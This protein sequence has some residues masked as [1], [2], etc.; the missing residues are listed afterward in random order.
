MTQRPITVIVVHE[1]SLC[2]AGIR[3]LLVAPDVRIVG[4][5]R[6]HDGALELAVKRRPRL[7]FV[8]ASL[9][10]AH[11]L[12]LVRRLKSAR[13]QTSV[14]VVTPF[15]SSEDLQ[16]A[17]A[18][19]CSGY[20][21]AAV[22]RVDLL[23]AARRIALG[24]CVIEPAALRSVLAKVGRESRRRVVPPDALTAPERDVLRLITD[25]RTNREIAVALRYSVGTVKDY[26]QRI[27]QKLDVSDRTQAAVKA[28]RLHLLD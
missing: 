4:E 13:P 18:A 24:E 17:L 15:P 22:P 12:H 11:H 10:G 2:R 26:V 7:A 14:V 27:I 1:H 19:G 3:A 16:R 5:A 6:T 25:G 20:L 23:R 8:G 21:D 28:V 9:P